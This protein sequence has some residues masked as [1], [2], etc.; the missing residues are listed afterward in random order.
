ME[1]KAVGAVILVDSDKLIVVEKQTIETVNGKVY[2]APEIDF[3]KGGIQANERLE[4]ALFRE[5]YEET[6]SDAY[7]PVA[8]I[9]QPLTF[10]FP[11]KVAN[12]IGFLTQKTY[13]YIVAFQGRLDE[14]TAND[15]EIKAIHVIK[16]EDIMSQLTHSETKDYY[17]TY[18]VNHVRS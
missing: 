12:Q 14:L 9:E 2:R 11:T 17:E 18:L 8:A 7:E 13:F 5:L 10:T 3:V 6:G 1:R 4:E 16:R 15:E